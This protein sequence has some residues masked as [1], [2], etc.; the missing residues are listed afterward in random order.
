MNAFDFDALHQQIVQAAKTAF[1]EMT[2]EHPDKDFCAFALYTD[3]G[4]MTVCPAFCTQSF[5]RE[6]QADNPDEYLYYKYSSNEWP[7]EGIGADEQ[8][9]RIC[10]TVR[11]HVFTLEEDSTAFAKFKTVL[12]ET[13]TQALHSLRNDTFTDPAFLLLFTI[14]DGDE[15]KKTQQQRVAG[16]NNISLATEFKAWSNTW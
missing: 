5:L 8:F 14:S 9:E 12:I 11:D 1:G 3:D 15:P 16:L 2:R 6:M 4:A 7:F 13:C 10:S